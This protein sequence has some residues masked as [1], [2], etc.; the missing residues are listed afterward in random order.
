MS[1][2]RSTH[3]RNE[4]ENEPKADPSAAPGTAHGIAPGANGG[5]ADAAAAAS[6]FVPGETPVVE[7]GTSIPTFLAYA[8]TGD[9][10][11]D[12]DVDAEPRPLDRTWK[13]VNGGTAS[14]PKQDYLVSSG[15]TGVMPMLTPRKA[16]TQE[17]PND[18][19]NGR[20]LAQGAAGAVRNLGSLMA[21]GAGAIQEMNAARKALADAR[22]DFK[23]LMGRIEAAAA[24]LEHRRD[25]E[26]RYGEIVASESTAKENALKEAAAAEVQ[27][28]GI[29][30][31]IDALKGE[32][33]QIREDDAQT[34]K[35]LK[36]AVDALEAEEA[37]S[38]ESSTRL[39][40]RL[41][42]AKRLLAK[43]EE[44]RTSGV[45][46][47]QTSITRA[48]ERLETLRAEY[49]EL[50]Q[51][52]SANSANYSVRISQLNSEISDAASALREAEAALPQTRLELDQAVEAARKAVEAA[53]QPIENASQE[54]RAVTAR[55][56]V[57]RDELQSAKTAAAERQR[58]QREKISEQ[59]KARREAEQRIE[60][61]G[62][63][64]NAAQA[65]IDE[66]IDI[67]EHPEITEAIAGT[68]AA[69]RREAAELEREVAELEMA[70]QRVRESTRGSRARFVAI[71]VAAIV[72]V[73]AIIVAVVALAN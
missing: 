1:D 40:R 3:S 18:A 4:I 7:A 25:I 23:T 47:A 27:R 58:T 49:T 42:D 50:Q 71:I 12:F 54:H 22:H 44:E 48:R 57:A 26:S 64:A 21:Q 51:N 72:I 28:D 16:G 11:A 30:Q 2:E 29:K 35:R 14:F 6:T 39:T 15:G 55:A 5:A 24:E 20:N 56:D 19:G 17:Q 59:E 33:Q 41:D 67:H 34:E 60:Q 13:V 53:Q 69:D 66:A 61:A 63:E 8:A 10:T 65:A 45:A 73:L 32:L 68:L 31:K 37:T 36:A 38:L 52:P 43:T 70:E 9:E 46:A 62:A